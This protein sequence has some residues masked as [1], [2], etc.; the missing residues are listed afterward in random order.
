MNERTTIGGTVYETIGSSSSN[1]LLRCNGT[2][3]IQWGNK[4]IDLIKNG[5][6]NSENANIPIYLIQDKLDIK[7]DGIYIIESDDSLQFWLCKNGKSYNLIDSDLYISTT[8]KQKI[9]AEQQKLV[10]ENIG[11]YFKSTQDVETSGIQEGLVYVLDEQKLYTIKDGILSEFTTL[12]TVTVE[13]ENKQSDDINSSISNEITSNAYQNF[14]RGMIVMYSGLSSIPEG[15]AICDGS[16]HIV[17][18]VPVTTPN[19]VNRFIKA[20][21]DPNLVGPTDNSDLNSS[22]EFTLRKE[23][24]PKHTH[25]HE[26]HTHNISELS[27]A[28]NNSGSLNLSLN[29]DYVESVTTESTLVLPGNETVESV[30]VVHNVSEQIQ[31]GSVVG[32]DHTHALTATNFEISST[33]SN[34][35][36]QI[37]ENNSFKIEPNYYSLIFIM[38]L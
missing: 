19:L 6:I 18:G 34:E 13:Q 2:A 17:D 3:R 27:N 26:E 28:I 11:M 4:L 10:M 12:K 20:V 5:K 33:T 31:N 22:N 8:S 32:G 25:H 38:K 24:L 29:S 15:W 9:T 7:S 35:L 16:T 21:V 1:L 36:E 14:T 30:E 37:W 23:H